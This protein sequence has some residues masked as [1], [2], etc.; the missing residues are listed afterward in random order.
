MIEKIYYLVDWIFPKKATWSGTPF[1]VLNALEK[2]IKVVDVDI[3]N[4]KGTRLERGIVKRIERL[5]DMSLAL[6][7]YN[8]IKHRIHNKE[9][10]II[11]QLSEVIFNDKYTKTYIYHDLTYKYLYDLYKNNRETFNYSGNKGRACS[12]MMNLRS[13]YEMYYHKKKCSCVFCMGKWLYNILIEKYNYSPDKVCHVGGGINVTLE[14]LS[15][16]KKL[17][18][19]ILFVGVDFERKGGYITYEA[20]KLLRNKNKSLEL[21][22]AGPHE[23]P[24]EEP[25][26]GYYYYG[27]VSSEKALELYGKCDI[28]CMPSYFEAYGLVFIEALACGLPC[29]GRDRYEMPYFIEKGVTGELLTNDDPEQLA[30]LIDTIFKTEQYFENVKN[31]YNYY[32]NEYSWDTVVNRMIDKINQK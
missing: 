28:F 1:G 9:K 6:V 24:I 27:K 31:R 12:F 15:L 8:R 14:K 32:V 2:K 13:R 30:K 25:I 16:Q 23:N 7:L 19:K 5:P 18:N 17:R 22:V 10:K 20:F 4:K 11:L 26:D 21:H 3:N 29:I